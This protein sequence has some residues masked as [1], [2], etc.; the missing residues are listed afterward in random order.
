MKIQCPC[1][2]LIHDGSD[3]QPNK[4]WLL[5]D[6]DWSTVMNRPGPPASFT[7]SL[8]L[9][10]ILYQCWSCGRL[11]L[12]DPVTGEMLWFAPEHD[13]RGKALGS[14]LGNA[15][16]VSL[17]G[18]W[19]GAAGDLHWGTSG[20]CPGGFEQFDD[21]EALVRRYQ[22]VLAQLKAEGRLQAARLTGTGA[23]HAWP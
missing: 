20:D 16:P 18:A 17:T 8:G 14:K 9:M 1:G 4:A 23:D 5:A 11:T 10:R 3:A 12:D 7:D 13:P 6:Q 22:E 2:E 15:Y 19:R 21:R